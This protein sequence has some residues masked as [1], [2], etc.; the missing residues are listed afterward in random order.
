MKRKGPSSRPQLGIGGAPIRPMTM[1]TASEDRKRVPLASGLFDYFG[2]ALIAVA[3]V[4]WYGNVQH[5]PGQLLHWDRSKSG[6]EA[7]TL[8]RHVMERG[9]LDTDGR[10]HSA[11]AAWRALALLQKEIEAEPGYGQSR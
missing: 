3:E 7:D 4:S 6:D 11:K 8:L 2:D 1:P 9:S 10:R 5:N